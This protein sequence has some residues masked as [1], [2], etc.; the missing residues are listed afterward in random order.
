MLLRVGLVPEDDRFVGLLDD[1]LR[2]SLFVL[3]LRLDSAGLVSFGLPLLLLV[4][5]L[6]RVGVGS[7]DILDLLSRGGEL[8]D[9]V[10]SRGGLTEGSA[11]LLVVLLLLLLVPDDFFFR[12]FLKAEVEVGESGDVG[13]SGFFMRLLCV[14]DSTSEDPSEDIGDVE[15]SAIIY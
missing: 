5:L 1:L 6:F 4:V 8:L 10:L 7:V 2:P 12:R 3:L 14:G 11:G 13:G 9:V 15:F